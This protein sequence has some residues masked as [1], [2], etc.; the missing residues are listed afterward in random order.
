MTERLEERERAVVRAHYGLGQPPQ[1]L[2]A[3]G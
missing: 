2:E 1:T 3:I